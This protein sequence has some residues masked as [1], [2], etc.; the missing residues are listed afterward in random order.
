MI[1]LSLKVRFLLCKYNYV[2]EEH[3]LIKAL[4]E[5]KWIKLL[6][7][8]VQHYGYE[9]VYG[10]NNVDVTRKI[11]DMPSFLDFLIPRLEKVLKSYKVIG[12]HEVAPV[13]ID[14]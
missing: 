14:E 10:S 2:E 9:F 4:D 5:N 3:D 11:G 13:T 1:I 7:R 12:N 8:R 6:N